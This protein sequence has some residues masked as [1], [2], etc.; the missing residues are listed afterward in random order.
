MDS[1][2]RAYNLMGLLMALLKSKRGRV[3]PEQTE[4]LLNVTLG[5]LV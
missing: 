3:D 2:N 4:E 5:V 1:G